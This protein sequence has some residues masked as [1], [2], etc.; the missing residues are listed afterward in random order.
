MFD[1]GGRAPQAKT[2]R[3]PAKQL[4]VDVTL[5]TVATASLGTILLTSI[6]TVRPVPSFPDAPPSSG[7]RVS[8]TRVGAIGTKPDGSMLGSPA[9]DAPLSGPPVCA[10][11]ARHLPIAVCASSPFLMK[12]A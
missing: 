12:F 7:S 9:G 4:P 11:V 2:V 8:S 10:S 1:V 3:K 5:N 6:D